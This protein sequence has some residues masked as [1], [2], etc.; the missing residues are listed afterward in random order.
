MN[1][2]KVD[3]LD[4]LDKT[5]E[6]LKSIITSE[7]M[8][9]ILK[10]YTP[11]KTDDNN[12]YERIFNSFDKLSIDQEGYDRASKVTMI[13]K[14]KDELKTIHCDKKSGLIV[15]TDNSKRKEISKMTEDVDLSMINMEDNCTYYKFEF[16][17]IGKYDPD[18]NNYYSYE[19][20]NWV[21]NGTIM[22]WVEDGAYPFEEI[23]KERKIPRL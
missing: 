11:G 19:D 17:I 5:L 2:N 15:I 22:R 23:K 20:G 12:S 9:Y 13:L 21:I 8:L 3:F 6:Y 1:T 4:D 14:N 10:F 16:G 18:T 7:D